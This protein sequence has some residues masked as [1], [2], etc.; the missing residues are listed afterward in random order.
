M[1]L[2]RH[3]INF[4]TTVNDIFRL[5]V[6]IAKTEKS[7]YFVRLVGI[8]TL[9][10]ILSS[11]RCSEKIVTSHAKK[12]FH[13]FFLIVS[14]DYKINNNP[15]CNSAKS[16]IRQ[17]TGE[18][19]W[20][21]ENFLPGMREDTEGRWVVYTQISIILSDQFTRWNRNQT[22]EKLLDNCQ[23]PGNSSLQL[24]RYVSWNT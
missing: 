17:S 1:F 7:Y 4:V 23:Y 18:L 13:L 24:Y 5:Y 6:G 10:Q 21:E 22:S 12:K 2:R 19:K 16:A 3:V 15:V 11:S 9:W 8:Q 14:I 20:K